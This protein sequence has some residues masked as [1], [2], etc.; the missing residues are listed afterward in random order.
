MTNYEIFEWGFP[1][2][3]FGF[4]SVCVPIFTLLA[5]FARFLTI[6][7]LIPTFLDVARKKHRLQAWISSSNLFLCRK[8]GRYFSSHLFSCTLA[9][10][11]VVCEN[12]GKVVKFLWW[13][14]RCVRCQQTVVIRF[15]ICI[16]VLRYS[17]RDCVLVFHCIPFDWEC[18][19][20]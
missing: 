18:F 14:I 20:I 16:A 8:A 13:V 6:Q 1:S 15:A 17:P 11:L 12:R 5:Q 4:L 3:Q 19:I 9:Q 2:T 7:Q 10:K